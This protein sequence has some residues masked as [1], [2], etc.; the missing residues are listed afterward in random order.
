MQQLY[1]NVSPIPVI[2]HGL[3]SMSDKSQTSFDMMLEAAD[4]AAE[5][6]ANNDAQTKAE[7]ISPNAPV[8]DV[9]AILP[10]RG[11]IV[12]PLSAVPLR[13]SQPRSIKLIDDTVLNKSVIG[14][15]ASNTHRERG[16][17]HRGYPPHRHTRNHRP[18][19]Q[20]A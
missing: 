18:P 5:V 19:F 17:R 13:V 9:I 1:L 16:T 11:A 7:I 2:V 3:Q 12:Y 10:L 6:A 15:I 20:G 8:P 4:I 14:L